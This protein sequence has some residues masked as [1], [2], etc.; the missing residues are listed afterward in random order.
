MVVICVYVRAYSAMFATS[1]SLS[2][3]SSASYSTMNATG[4]LFQLYGEHFV[5]SIPVALT[6]NSPQPAPQYPMTRIQRWRSR[7]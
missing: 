6:G 3:F 7:S 2:L 4:L 5:G 1:K